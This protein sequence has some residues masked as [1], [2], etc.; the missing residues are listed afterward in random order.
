MGLEGLG[1]KGE[2]HRRYAGFC[3]QQ[4]H[5]P[6]GLEYICFKQI[7]VDTHR[8]NGLKLEKRGTSREATAVMQD[9][10]VKG[11]QP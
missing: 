8:V 10:K 3:F 7:L 1:G 9:S 11:L 5:L 6:Q 4:H 2:A